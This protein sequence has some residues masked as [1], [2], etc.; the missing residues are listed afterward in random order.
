MIPVVSTPS[1][2]L[3]GVQGAD[4]IDRY[5]GIPYA[6]A[7]RFAPPS[8]E[9]AWSGVREALAYGPA[10]PQVPT[11][12]DKL[13]AGDDL[14]TDEAAC[15]TVNVWTP[16][17][18]DGR[19]PVL[20]WIHGGA[21]ATGTGRSR[22]YD[23]AA[24]ARRGDVV[25]VTLNYR[26]GVLGFTHGIAAG[27][28]NLGLLD[29]VVAL[30]WVRD[31]IAAFGGD[32]GNV[33][34]FGESAGGCS[35]VALLAM[36]ASRGLFHR[37]ISQSPSLTQLRA[38]ARAE[39][40]TAELLDAAGLGAH[41]H[42]ALR[43]LD[44]DVLVDRQNTLLVDSPA[45]IT[46]ASPTAD[47][48]V[49]PATLTGVLAAAAARDVPL[50]LG[51]TADEMALFTAFDT[52]HASLDEAMLGAILRRTFGEAGPRALAAYR[53]VRPDAS[54]PE[55]ATAVATDATFRIPA[56]RLAEARVAAGTSTW[57]YRF[58]WPSP[59]FGGVLGACHGI[60]IPFVFHN[61][62]QPGVE[63]FLGSGPERAALADIT[64]EVWLAFARNGRG[65]WEPYD[66]QERQVLRIDT[67]PH[68]ELDPES[69]TRL[70]WEGIAAW[71]Q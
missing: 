71:P 51:T 32:P 59:A 20:V 10:A 11:V 22:W 57:L 39:Q 55:L 13:L 4:G 64:A 61:L 30:T 47:G 50:L 33:T 38:T 29:Q 31:H 69:A 23:G 42:E 19:R 18:D 27:S 7:T 49:L 53:E 70:A 67:Q 65:G 48:H 66:V 12:L 14:V 68:V 54:P 36:E 26:L 1:G 46:A 24:L 16:A 15:L 8:P 25:M 35:V 60:E 28:G 3:Q 44:T 52:R 34:V 45:G 2:R 62:H 37:A 9:P 17:S 41:D 5:L 58:T 40:A 21:F 43:A 6:R 56:M 63:L